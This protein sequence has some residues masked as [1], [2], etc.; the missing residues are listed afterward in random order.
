MKIAIINREKEIDISIYR[1]R[2][3]GQRDM[4]TEVQRVRGTERQRNRETEGERDREIAI[5]KDSVRET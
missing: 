4:G 3:E 5:L 2:Q 1:Q